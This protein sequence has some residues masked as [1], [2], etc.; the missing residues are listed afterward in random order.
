MEYVGSALVAPPAALKSCCNGWLLQRACLPG[1]LAGLFLWMATPPLHLI[2]WCSSS[3]PR[4]GSAHMSSLPWEGAPLLSA[5]LDQGGGACLGSNL[6]IGPSIDRS[7]D[8]TKGLLWERVMEWA[9][10]KEKRL[11]LG[12]NVK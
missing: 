9:V 12:D 11:G 2:W 3:S 10:E 6:F 1:W 8:Q 7:I 4:A 5:A